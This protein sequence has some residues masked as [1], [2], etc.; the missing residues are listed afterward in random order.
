MTKIK[1]KTW[2]LLQFFNFW[3]NINY[4]E[5]E[6]NQKYLL[7][8]KIWFLILEDNLKS[9][10]NIHKNKIFDAIYDFLK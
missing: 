1:V 8:F 10:Q 3:K 4:W 5:L 2:F 7:R 9:D 6:N